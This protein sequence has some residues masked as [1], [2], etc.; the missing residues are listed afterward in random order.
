MDEWE[1][2]T[3]ENST[4]G[5]IV[6]VFNLEFNNVARKLFSEESED[7]VPSDEEVLQDLTILEFPKIEVQR[8]VLSTL[9]GTETENFIF[10][11]H[12]MVFRGDYKGISSLWKHSNSD[13]RAMQDL[14]DLRGNTP[15]MLASK[16]LSSGKTHEKIFKFL[17]FHGANHKVKD[18]C[19]WSIM[20]EIVIQ[21]N[22]A[23]CSSFFDHLYREKLLKWKENKHLALSAL[24]RLP[25]FYVEISW[26]FGSSVIP[27]VSRIA[28]HDV[29]KLFKIGNCFRIDTS[30]VGWRKLRSKR[31]PMSFFFIPQ[32]EDNL[33]DEV[34]VANHSKQV[35][36]KTF[37]PLDPEENAAVVND[38]LMTEPM[39]GDVNIL[40]YKV[41]TCLNWRGRPCSSKVGDWECF[42]HKVSYRGQIKYKK[43]VKSLGKCCENKYFGEVLNENEENSQIFSYSSNKEPTKTMVKK[44]KA[45][46]WLSKDFPFTLQDFLPVLQIVSESNSTIK[47]LYTFLSDQNLLSQ[48]GPESFPVKIDIPLTLSLKAVVTF[49]K[50]RLISDK[51]LI[52][53]PS[54]NFES[55]KTAQKTLTCPKKR[56]LLANLVI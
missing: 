44:S 13:F 35:R 53:P 52:E 38:I 6:P 56:I 41:K 23:A 18:P 25:D 24:S 15:L 32:T 17:L 42:K 27:L 43:K 4:E 3:E 48:I 7:E 20:D 21:K 30:L 45:F 40:T 9:S 55:R 39:Q 36:V 8:E 11:L 5:I 34:F 14:L 28:P 31:R 16:L 54:Y 37:E 49:D 10:A 47:K 51:S 22:Q 1:L 12:L 29:C 50:F 26:E 46:V 33:A 19:G 2:D